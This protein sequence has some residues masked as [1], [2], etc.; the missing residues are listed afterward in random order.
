MKC[1]YLLS[2]QLLHNTFSNDNEKKK[3]L[4]DVKKVFNL[5]KIYIYK[6]RS[7]VQNIK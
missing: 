1:S 3:V 2:Q 5:L 7:Q 6:T 4:C